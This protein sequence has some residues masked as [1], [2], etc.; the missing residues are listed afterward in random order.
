MNSF[1][2]GCLPEDLRLTDLVIIVM[3]KEANICRRSALNG[4]ARDKIEVVKTRVAAIIVAERCQIR[5]WLRALAI[6]T[7]RCSDL[8]GYYDEGKAIEI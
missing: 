6:W 2:R 1:L 5:G 7:E 4:I 8:G 3:D